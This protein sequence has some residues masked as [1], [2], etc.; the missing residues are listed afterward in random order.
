MFQN[1]EEAGRLLA[2]RL[3]QYRA[4]AATI[5]LALPRGGAAVGYPMS[6]EL[7]LPLDVFITRK[8]GAPE[9]PEFAIG[10]ISE[11]GAVYVNRDSAELCG[12]SQSDLARLLRQER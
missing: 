12:A 11:S 7:R 1:R 3:R 5:I 6:L 2:A 9:N 10:A 4:D 8:V